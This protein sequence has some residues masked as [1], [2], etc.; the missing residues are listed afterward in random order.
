MISSIQ[1]K[2]LK[3]VGVR[4]A[5]SP[6]AVFKA[7]NPT[8]KSFSIQ[9]CSVNVA[10]R[11]RHQVSA[12]AVHLSAETTDSMKLAAGYHW[13]ETMIIMMASM[14]DD[15]R[16]K[17]VAKFQAFLYK[18]EC[19]HINTQVK[20]RARLAYP[21]KTCWEGN[22]VLYTYAAKRQTAKAVQLLLSKP[23]A[24]SENNILRH[25]TLCKN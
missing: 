23:E 13:Y 15:T 1:T 21:I 11:T 14:S 10:P 17:E 5:C 16:D 4:K 6:V 18:E 25:M 12:S 24:G 3:S 19:Q 9:P 20:G 7:V 22:F 8:S 2:G